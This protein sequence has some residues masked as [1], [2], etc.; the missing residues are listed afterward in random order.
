MEQIKIRDLHIKTGEWVRRA[1]SG[2]ELTPKRLD[3]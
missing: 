1:T 3:T 2:E